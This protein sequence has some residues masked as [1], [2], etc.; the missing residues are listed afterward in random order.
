MLA[1]LVGINIFVVYY[2]TLYFYIIIFV[3]VMLY[4]I[5]SNSDGL[6]NENSLSVWREGQRIKLGKAGCPSNLG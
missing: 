1:S 2:A 5:I 6:N 3:S 4:S